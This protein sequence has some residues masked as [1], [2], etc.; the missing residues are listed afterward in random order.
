M[1]DNSL[2]KL[3]KKLES[4]SSKD[5]LLSKFVLKPN[6]DKTEILQ[7]RNFLK[8]IGSFVDNF[9][10]QNNEILTD[11][12]KIKTLNIEEGAE[13]AKNNSKKKADKKKKLKSKDKN[14]QKNINEHNNN[15][16]DSDNEENNNL[17]D[18]SKVKEKKFIELNLKLGVLD[19]IKKDTNKVLIEDVTDK[20]PE[21]EKN[22]DEIID[23]SSDYE[24]NN[25]IKII[26]SNK[27]KNYLDILKRN[28]NILQS[29]VNNQISK[30]D[31]NPS[32]ED[33]PFLDLKNDTFNKEVLNFLLENSKNANNDVK[34]KR[35][36]LGKKK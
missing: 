5:I 8:N 9:K 33:Y 26:R 29:V 7:G 24:K 6:I 21:K 1:R 22:K 10:K 18:E 19:L 30:N 32:I 2:L 17:N 23:N 35:R 4:F 3:E 12:N 27:G 36:I 11:E 16:E 34:K 13:L 20:N 25:N 31:E 28:D 14:F 15:N